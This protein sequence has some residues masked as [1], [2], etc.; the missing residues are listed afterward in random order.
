VFNL[1]PL[2]PLDGGRL[3]QVIGAFYAG[4]LRTGIVLSRLSCLLSYIITAFGVLQLIYYGK[5]FILP[6]G[7]FLV[8]INRKE[9]INNAYSFYKAL[10]N[11]RMNRAMPVRELAFSPQTSLKTVM[12]RLGV[13]YYCVVNVVGADGIKARLDENIIKQY[14]I[15]HGM[16]NKLVD[17][18]LQFDY[19]GR[20]I[21]YGG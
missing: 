13:D 14:I 4:T 16:Q 19:N 5:P 17:I 20:N 10:I 1:L 11:K 3:V 8:R 21:S 6:I 2:Y 18:M 12:Y 7:I 9:Y 15:N